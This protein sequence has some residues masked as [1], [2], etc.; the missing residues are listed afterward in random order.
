[1][2]LYLFKRIHLLLILKKDETNE[3]L[4]YDHVFTSDVVKLGREKSVFYVYIEICCVENNIGLN[5]IILIQKLWVITMKN[6][7]LLFHQVKT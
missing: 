5:T 1:M 4:F 7:L 6:Y 3:L 2:F